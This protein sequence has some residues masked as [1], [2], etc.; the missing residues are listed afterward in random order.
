MVMNLAKVRRDSL[1]YIECYSSPI[2]IAHVKDL[3]VMTMDLRVGTRVLD[4]D[5][6]KAQVRTHGEIGNRS[7][8]GDGG[9]D[10]MEDTFGAR[11]GESETP[12]DEGRDKHHCSDGLSHCQ[13][14]V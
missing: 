12:E 4:G 9:G 14:R 13:L 3:T 5:G 1:E 10:V 2:D 8:Q 6:C 11:F 7:D